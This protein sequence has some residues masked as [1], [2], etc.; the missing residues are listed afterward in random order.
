ME[1]DGG[2]A[3][4]QNPA[5]EIPLGPAIPLT[6]KVPVSNQPSR[7]PLL[8]PKLVACHF[9]APLR[10]EIVRAETYAEALSIACD[11][12]PERSKNLDTKCRQTLGKM[13][14]ETAYGPLQRI[15]LRDIR[16]ALWIV[17]EV[18]REKK[19]FPRGDYQRV[20]KEALDFFVIDR[21]NEAYRT[22]NSLTTERRDNAFAK[23]A[24]VWNGVRDLL[25]VELENLLQPDTS[26]NIASGV[27]MIT[28]F[29]HDRAYLRTH[30]QTL[31]DITQPRP[32]L[33][34]AEYDV[35]AAEVTWGTS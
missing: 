10:K 5:S 34:E 2:G 30:L 4:N 17:R 12:D 24:M 13:I 19:F 25:N 9:Y 15:E 7:R 18:L 26:P 22:L 23:G 20:A 33:R 28:G 32:R 1:R 31:P 27:L 6:L 29:D 35:N 3:L 16:A 14:P 21:R 11:Y 8:T